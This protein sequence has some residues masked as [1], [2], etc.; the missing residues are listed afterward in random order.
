MKILNGKGQKIAEFIFAEDAARCIGP[1]ARALG[2]APHTE[3][4]TE[5]VATNLPRNVT[6]EPLVG[7]NAKRSRLVAKP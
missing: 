3:D 2:Y 5:A 1:M 7:N 4:T 6:I